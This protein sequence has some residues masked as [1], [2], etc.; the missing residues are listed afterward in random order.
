M[1]LHTRETTR[2]N[3]N[4]E[5]LTSTVSFKVN[6]RAIRSLPYALFPSVVWIF[7]HRL[8]HHGLY[9]RVYHSSRIHATCNTN[10]DIIWDSSSCNCSCDRYQTPATAWTTITTPLPSPTSC[11]RPA[12]GSQVIPGTIS[13]T[14]YLTIDNQ[15]DY[16]AIITLRESA[17]PPESGKKVYSYY[18]RA[19]DQYTFS[20]I[21]PGSYTLWY[22]LGEC[23]DPATKKF[24]VDKGA[25]RFEEVL[26]YDY[27]TAGYSAKIYGVVG[28]NAPTAGVSADQV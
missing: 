21:P 24:S 18:L 17:I 25:R 1:R 15:N 9:R 6:S 22:K 23:W 19:N 13:G 2:K 28:G 3:L 8:C 26:D 16:D 14:K 11:A 20:T 27:N 12:T 7:H 10:G 4:P 5:E